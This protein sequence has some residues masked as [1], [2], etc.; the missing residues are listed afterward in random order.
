[1]GH[2]FRHESPPFTLLLSLP[3]PERLASLRLQGRR[4]AASD[5]AQSTFSFLTSL[6]FNLEPPIAGPLSIR[7]HS[8]YVCRWGEGWFWVIKDGGPGWSVNKTDEA[9]IEFR[10][11]LLLDIFGR[12]RTTLPKVLED[13]GPL[14]LEDR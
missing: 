10:V 3:L 6:G 11:K 14:P 8:G 13:I 5:F 7:G 9:A 2:T 12:T 1:M 4:A